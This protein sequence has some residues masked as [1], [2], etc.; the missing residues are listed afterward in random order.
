VSD[1]ERG[2][3]TDHGGSHPAVEIVDLDW[4]SAVAVLI[5]VGAVLTAF[6]LAG[7]AH[8]TLTWVA[9]GVLLSL[10]LD[11]LVNAVERRLHARRGAAV[12][13]VLGV[14]VV[15]VGLAVLLLGPP[16]LREAKSFSHD[17]PG[18]INRLGELP[19]VGDRLR[20]SD[21]PAKLIK[22]L[23]ELPSRLGSS[24]AP[25]EKLVSTVLGG[26]LAT[27]S[28]VL[29]TTVV[30]LDGPHLIAGLRRLVP[31]RRRP[32]A[33]RV[34]TV[35]Y[36][37]V[38]RYF[39]GSL[40]MAVLTG[41]AMLIS[42]LVLGVPLILIA[43]VWAML[44]NM[45]P[46]IGGFLGGSLFVILALSKSPGTGVAALAYFLLW[47]QLENHV[48]QPTIV[49]EAVNLTPPATMLAALIGGATAGVPGALVAVPLLGTAKA[50]YNEIRPPAVVE[51]TDRAK[52]PGWARRGIRKVL[53]R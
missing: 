17:L 24:D 2:I 11:P 10:A 1:A 15:A 39:A 51:P 41:T 3:T 43:S 20:K 50:V 25:L 30:L 34:G 27:F 38:G 28:T 48:L 22:W 23:N 31:S 37:T 6:A 9:I 44:T 33:E 4:R 52:R 7:S 49:G 53:R 45:I 21:T 36:R 29:V 32:R 40:F 26:A 19:L 14:F 13:I 16:A 42:G 5:A 12:A 46:Q 35:L 18:V 8:Q 47:Q